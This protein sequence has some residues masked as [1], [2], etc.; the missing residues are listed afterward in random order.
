MKNLINLKTPIEVAEKLLQEK[1]VGII[2]H[3]R[4]DGDSIGSAIALCLG[5]KDV[6]VDADVLCADDIPDKFSFINN[7]NMV[8]KG[9]DRDYSAL[10]SV[11]C[12]ELSRLGEFSELYINHK[13]T[14]NIDH[15]LSNTK[16]GKYNYVC[17]KPS[18]CE[19]VYEI[20]KALE[21]KI[22]KEIATLLFMGLMTDTGGFRHKGVL[23][24]TYKIAG[25][26][27]EYGASPNEIYYNC[28][29]KQSKGR[30]K[31]F[32]IV[33]SKIRY[34]LDDRF[35][36]ASVFIEDIEKTGAKPS[37][38]EGMIDFVMGIE[39]VEVGVCILETAKN[40]FKISFRGK[41]TD[42]NEIAGCFGGGGHKFASGCQIFGEYEEVIDKLH[43]A[44][45]S[46]L[47]D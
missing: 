10:V 8:K 28:F 44:V 21:A 11:D 4:P 32:G 37:D 1:N 24:S 31:L 41:E 27:I 14:F 29:S 34:F 12:G 38:T 13:N 39:G 33:A 30:A 42:V 20:L 46:H 2:F 23:G 9:A 40:K 18:N 36:V 3:I 45:K 35:A 5:L 15:H 22:T 17:T 16:F 25:E 43:Y 47:R 19:N 26:L 7:I 6:G